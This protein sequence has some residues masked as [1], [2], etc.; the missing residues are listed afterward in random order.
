MLGNTY[1]ESVVWRALLG[2]VQIAL[3]GVL[4][5]VKSLSRVEIYSHAKSQR[6]H[7]WKRKGQSRADGDRYRSFKGTG[8]EDCVAREG[9]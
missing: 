8:A 6:L 1:I 2:E 3:I 5:N 7:L 9:H 4:Q